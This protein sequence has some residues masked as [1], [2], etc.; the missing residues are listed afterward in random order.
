MT[1]SVIT[2]CAI[3]AA[4]S[5]GAKKN[6]KKSVSEEE[7]PFGTQSMK[8]VC[9]H[10]NRMCR[11]FHQQGTSAGAFHLEY[12]KNEDTK[13]DNTQ[14]DETI[15]ANNFKIGINDYG[16]SSN[17]MD[18]IIETVNKNQSFEIEIIKKEVTED[19]VMEDASRIK[20]NLEDNIIAGYYDVTIDLKTNNEHLD[21]ITNLSHNI[22]LILPVPSNLPS[23]MEGYQREYVV[24]RVHD[25]VVSKVNANLNDQG[26]LEVNTKEF[27]TYAI[28]YHDV[29]IQDVSSGINSNSTN[30][31]V[32]IICGITLVILIAV[33]TFISIKRKNNEFE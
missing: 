3:A 13:Q 28:A 24:Y 18:K 29:L 5:N 23:I 33:I 2:N 8:D 22:K 12:D 14:T 30:N 10:H 16:L 20:N 26:M 27:S 21:N 15:A 1:V 9:S 4:I 6:G 25:N 7:M 19:E 32:L 31:K 11:Y 17:I